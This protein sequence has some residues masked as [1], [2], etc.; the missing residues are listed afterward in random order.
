MKKINHI[1]NKVFATY[2]KKKKKKKK[3]STGNND[4]KYYKV[5]YH[6]HYKGRYGGAAHKICN[7][8]YKILKEIPGVFHNGSTNYHFIITELA[9]EF[10]GKFECLSKNTEK[11]ITFSVPRNEELENGKIITYK[12][13]F[14]YSFRFVSSSLSS[15]VDNLAEG[16]YSDKWIYCKSCLIYIFQLLKM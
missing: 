11:Y 7:L 1:I 16:L 6:C 12:M 13:K 14:I 9:K 10:K 8:R 2:T 15:L 4:K 5:R 3:I